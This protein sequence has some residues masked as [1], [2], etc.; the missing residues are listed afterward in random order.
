MKITYYFYILRYHVL[1]RKLT[2]YFIGVYIILNYRVIFG[3]LEYR[4]LEWLKKY[5]EVLI[6][7]YISGRK[8]NAK[9]FRK[10]SEISRLQIL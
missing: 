2:W 10:T 3:K 1:P 4:Y 5:Q 8:K 9:Y 7:N 6:I